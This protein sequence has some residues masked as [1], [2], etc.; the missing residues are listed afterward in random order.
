MLHGHETV[1]VGGNGPQRKQ[2]AERR[3]HDRRRIEFERVEQL[4]D[5]RTQ[6]D[7]ANMMTDGDWTDRHVARAPV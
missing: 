2:A 6:T 3:R 7:L 1:R 4:D 5:R